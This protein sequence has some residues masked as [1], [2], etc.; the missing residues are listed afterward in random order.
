MTPKSLDILVT[1]I[2]LKTKLCFPSFRMLCKIIFLLGPKK[3]MVQLQPIAVLQNP[4]L[5]QNL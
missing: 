3:N 4:F 2:S 5:K 1:R